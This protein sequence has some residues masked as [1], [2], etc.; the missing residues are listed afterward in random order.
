MEQTT[1][2]ML[3]PLVAV[4]VIMRVLALV[5]LYRAPSARHLPKPAWAAIIVIF[6]LFGWGAWF[7]AGRPEE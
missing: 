2:L 4:D 6:T 1:L 3:A 7:L 5:S